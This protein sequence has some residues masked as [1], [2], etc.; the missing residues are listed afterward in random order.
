MKHNFAFVVSVLSFPLLQI[1]PNPSAQRRF[2]FSALDYYA[3]QG[4]DQ[5]GLL[6]VLF[7]GI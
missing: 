1:G 3:T 7:H 5:S 6:F 2:N 4:V